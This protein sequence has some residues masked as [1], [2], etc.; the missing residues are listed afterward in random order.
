MNSDNNK[1]L[2][3]DPQVN[4]SQPSIAPSVIRIADLDA[5]DKPREKAI[6]YGIE[7][8]SNAE[9][10]AIIFGS[11]LP[12]KSVISL[13]Q[14]IL[15]DNSNRLSRVAK[16]SI[17]EL[18]S[19]YG[20]IGPAKAVSLAAAFELGTR[21]QQDL[22]VKDPQVTDSRSVYNMMRQAMERLPYEQF[23]VLY[24]NRANRVIFEECVSKGGTAGTVVDTKLIMKRAVDKLAAGLIFVHNHPSGN[25][26]PSVQ[27]RQLT[28]RL[29]KA[30]ELLDIRVLDHLIISADGFYSFSDNSML[31]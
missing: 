29:K 8:L 11:G 2:S 12:G 25:L 9:L 5:S 1:P 7:T 20:G 6:K 13:S 3:T 18:E 30:A 31:G 19:K 23:R 28:A 10:M 22:M 24:L 16:M 4:E 15:K 27:D 26:Q 14:E 21:C 17:H